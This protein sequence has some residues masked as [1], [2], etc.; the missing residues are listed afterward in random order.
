MLKTE[1]LTK[2][3]FEQ[4]KAALNK[5]TE[6][7]AKAMLVQLS[8][9]TLVLTLSKPELE[10]DFNSIEEAMEPLLSEQDKEALDS[11]HDIFEVI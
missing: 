5:L 11:C 1:I 2:E 8:L 7:Q 10:S 6:V 4:I 3:N 9:Y